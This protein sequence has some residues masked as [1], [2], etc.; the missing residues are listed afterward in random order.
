M[1]GCLPTHALRRL[2]HKRLIDYLPKHSQRL[3]SFQSHERISVRCGSS[4]HVSIDLMNIAEQPNSPLFIHLPSFPSNDKQP[5]PIPRFLQGKPLATI[6]YRWNSFDRE[7]IDHVWP[8]PIHD[9]SFAYKWLVENLAPEGIKRRDIYVY[10]SHLGASLA[11]SLA[12]TESQ[13]HKPFA[14]R[15][16]VSYNG[17]YNWTMF[18][19]DHPVNSP[20][21]FARNPKAYHRPLEGTYIHHLQYIMPALFKSTAD[22]FDVFASPSLFFHNP[23]IKVPSSYHMT[24]EESAAIEMM[25]NPEAEVD[26]PIKAPRRSRLVFPPRKSTLKLP[27]TLLLYDLLPTLPSTGVPGGP[28]IRRQ[29]GNSLEMQAKEL[30]GMMQS[31]IEKVELKERGLWDDEIAFWENEQGRRVKVKRAGAESVTMEMGEN[32]EQ[33]VEEWLTERISPKST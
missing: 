18:F 31:S 11:T 13:P 15:G 30:A 22:T 3:Y 29:W 4:G 10:G 32:G 28:R 6:N 9:T 20:G 27:E 33:L 2:G 17:I 8:T 16:L 14:V 12:L 25:T 26:P 23:G 21:Q 19:P 7:N 5:A 24:E 1:Q